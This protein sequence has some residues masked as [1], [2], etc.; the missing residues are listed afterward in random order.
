VVSLV[1]VMNGT[2][3]PGDKIRV[4]STGRSHIVDKLGASR[5]SP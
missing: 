5:R 2:L 1:R 3:R 4:M